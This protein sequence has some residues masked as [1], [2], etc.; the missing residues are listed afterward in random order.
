MLAPIAVRGTAVQLRLAFHSI[1]AVDVRFGGGMR[2]ASPINRQVRKPART[3][4][5]ARDTGAVRLWGNFTGREFGPGIRLDFF[6]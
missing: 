4:E 3:M 6:S 1:S 2:R 5:T